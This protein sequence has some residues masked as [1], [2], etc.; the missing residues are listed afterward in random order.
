MR[1]FL[2]L[3]LAL[4]AAARVAPRQEDAYAETQLL[5]GGGPSG[6]IAVATFDDIAGF[7]IIANDTR[8]GT[9]ASWLLFKPPNLVYAVDE[10]SN[11]TRL[12]TV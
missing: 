10:N 2:A 6:T 5:I 3:G 11:S 1:S 12:F 4:L 9:S 7:S 8:P